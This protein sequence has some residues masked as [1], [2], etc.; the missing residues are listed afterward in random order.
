MKPKEG[1]LL[2]EEL[3][4]A[5]HHWIKES[6]KSLSDRLKKGEL[7]KFSPYKVS[8]GIVRVGGRIVDVYPGQDGKVRNVRAKTTAG[9]YDRPVAKIAVLHPA[10]GYE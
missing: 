8:Y 2:P 7:I 9:V 5:E 1:P 3:Q 6:H 10:E 4:E